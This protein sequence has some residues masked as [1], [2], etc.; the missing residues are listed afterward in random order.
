MHISHFLARHHPGGAC[1]LCVG[2]LGF[3]SKVNI[4]SIPSSHLFMLVQLLLAMKS[5]FPSVSAELTKR[6]EDP[7]RVAVEEKLLQTIVV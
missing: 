1:F 3:I 4:T 2:I 6:K 7:F 5:S